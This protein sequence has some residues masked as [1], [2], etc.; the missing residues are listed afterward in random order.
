M[1]RLRRR[2]HAAR[3]QNQNTKKLILLVFMLQP[4]VLIVRIDIMFLLAAVDM[5]VCVE[6]F[7]DVFN[8]ADSTLVWSTFFKRTTA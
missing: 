3:D 1:A 2:R 5:Y 8:T 6:L 7:V 4:V